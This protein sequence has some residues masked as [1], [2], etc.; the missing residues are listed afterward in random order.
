MHEQELTPQLEAFAAQLAALRPA[1]GLCRERLLF[2]A[3]RASTE[4]RRASKLRRVAWPTLTLAV[5]AVALL[6]GRVTA[7]ATYRPIYTFNNL[8]T[9]A[10][11]I[12]TSPS[13]GEAI[14]AA[15]DSY[16]R[17]RDELAE[18]RPQPP[19]HVDHGPLP[20]PTVL[21]HELLN[22]LLN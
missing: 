20:S 5:G 11:S 8:G 10:T 7:P 18:V 15:D 6:L 2:E 16:L 13:D 1:T 9:P 17:L 22:E 4:E 21:R 12:E 14:A 19:R 3:G